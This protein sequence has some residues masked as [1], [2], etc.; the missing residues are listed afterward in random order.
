MLFY[1]VIVSGLFL[2][3]QTNIVRAG[4]QDSLCLFPDCFI[5]MNV[6][7]FSVV[8]CAADFNEAPTISKRPGKSLHFVCPLQCTDNHVFDHYNQQTDQYNKIQE[9]TTYDAIIHIINNNDAGTYRCWCNDTETSSYCHLKV[10]GKI[11]NGIQL[12]MW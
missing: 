12:N 2:C 7:K 9:G 5:T 8:I 10:E 11:L 1:L 4:R 6:Y 3:H